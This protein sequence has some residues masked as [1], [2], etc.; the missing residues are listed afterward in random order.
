FKQSAALG[1]HASLRQGIA[2]GYGHYVIFAALAALGAG[3]QT[4]VDDTTEAALLTAFGA[5]AGVAVPTSAYLLATGLLHGRGHVTALLRSVAP[6]AIL[7]LVVA[8]AA[9]VIGVA[10]AVFAMGLVTSGLIVQH[11]LASRNV[12]AS[13]AVPGATSAPEMASAAE[14]VL[15][16]E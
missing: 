16:A 8:A 14:P 7:V 10:A 5:A 13:A 6:S 11:L 12:G 2:W 3:L 9:P 4:A 1:A 15:T